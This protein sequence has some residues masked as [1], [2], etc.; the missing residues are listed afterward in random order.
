MPS[1]E[2]LRNKFI[3]NKNNEWIYIEFKNEY[4]EINSFDDGITN[5]ISYENKW[6]VFGKWKGKLALYN[7][8]FPNIIIHIISKWKVNDAKSLDDDL[9]WRVKLIEDT[10]PENNHPIPNSIEL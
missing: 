4:H 2:Y 7:L 6:V 10:F 3:Y 9:K 5:F 8:I 1:E